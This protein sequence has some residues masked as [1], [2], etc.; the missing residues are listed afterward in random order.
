MR[1]LCKDE[2]GN[3]ALVEAS[4]IGRS[5][6]ESHAIAITIAGGGAPLLCTD[7]ELFNKFDNKIKEEAS[8][9]YI[10]FSDYEFKAV[11]MPDLFTDLLSSMR[12]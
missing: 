9:P 8:H 4:T 1:V 10:D 11:M 5:T 6:S 7:E 12:K 3:P 2:N